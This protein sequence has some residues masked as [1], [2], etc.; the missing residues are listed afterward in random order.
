MN[1]NPEIKPKG[2]EPLKHIC[3]TIGELPSSYLETMTYYEMLLWFT[4]FLQEKMIPTLDNNALAIEELQN[5]YIELQSYVNNYFDNLDVQEEINNKLDSMA[6]AGTLQEIIDEY[7]KIKALIV[8]DTFS[9]MSEST[10]IVDGSYA[11]TLGFNTINDG[12]GALYKISD[13]GS[14]KGKIVILLENGLYAN[15]QADYYITPETFG[16][17]GDGTTDD[18]QPLQDALI[19]ANQNNIPLEL[20]KNT[21]Y[22]VNPKGQAVMSSYGG[23]PDLQYTAL[24][25]YGDVIIN[26]NNAT[27]KDIV[28][29]VQF[30]D[31]DT[32][33]GATFTPSGCICGYDSVIT[34]DYPAF[35]GNKITI[36][37]LNID[38]GLTSINVGSAVPGD[39]WQRHRGFNM[40][41]DYGDV[42]LTY[43]GGSIKNYYGEGMSG[44]SDKFIISVK[45]CTT[46]NCYPTPFNVQGK[47]S[48]YIGNTINCRTSQYASELNIHN[49]RT[50][51][52]KDNIIYMSNPKNNPVF[53]VWNADSSSSDNNKGLAIIENNTCYLNGHFWTCLIQ[54]WTINCHINFNKFY[55]TDY[56]RDSGQALFY[57]KDNANIIEMNG[58]LIK[59][60]SG[61]NYS[62]SLINASDF[63]GT[64]TKFISNVENI[65][66]INSTPQNFA[67][68]HYTPIK[69]T[70]LIKQTILIIMN[71][72][73]EKIVR[74]I[75]IH[76]SIDEIKLVMYNIYKQKK[77]A[78]NG[79]QGT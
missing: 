26:G 8:F 52:I 44:S 51:I 33:I 27:I 77:G 50:A 56:I 63:T 37:D 47:Y 42:E 39:R 5:L 34:T 2:I 55:I 20:K 35:G 46:D 54:A 10:N 45:G 17:V 43:N 62:A 64:I 74:F 48:E 3:M 59:F 69:F 16:A 49:G 70:I 75:K 57:F 32:D 29:Q 60:I 25:I 58:N 21:T 40:I 66:E 73:L 61:D 7:L 65:L 19:Y 36:N 22:R 6:E 41:G 11:K 79:R 68:G 38:G 9:D 4:K 24:I 71:V 23:Q 12:G 67:I 53:Y 31:G 1:N 28:T 30:N 76:F 72:S 78:K 15:L 18:T 13:T 14:P